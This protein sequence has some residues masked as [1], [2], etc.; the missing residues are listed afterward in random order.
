MR[1]VTKT[2]RVADAMTSLADDLLDEK[3]YGDS[4]YAKYQAQDLLVEY[5]SKWEE[6]HHDY[7]HITSTAGYTEAELAAAFAA[8]KLTY[9]NWVTMR[10]IA[11]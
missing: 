5:H 6:A 8:E 4:L 9:A 7:Q 11:E 10:A 3:R 1:G 2:C